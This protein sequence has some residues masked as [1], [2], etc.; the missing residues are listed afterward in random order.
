MFLIHT[1]CGVAMEVDNHGILR[2]PKCGKLIV[3]R[4]S[5]K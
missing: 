3:T 5:A 2:C 4:I 1:R